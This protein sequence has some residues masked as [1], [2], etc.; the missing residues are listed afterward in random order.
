MLIAVN[1][2][3]VRP[4]FDYPYEG[5]HGVTIDQFRRQL[6]L[7]AEKAPFVSAADVRAAVRGERL[8]P[9]QC[10]LVTLDDGLKE[11]YEYAWPVLRS[12]GIPAIFYVTTDSIQNRRL[13]AV[14]KIHLLRA[15]VAPETLA[16][17]MDRHALQLG[18]NRGGGGSGKSLQTVPLRPT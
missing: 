11:Q 2:H 5:I 9:Q 17:A 4:R 18:I 13:A 12:L 7:L 1:F 14:H 3:Y 8:L 6:A 15:T 10:W 16:W